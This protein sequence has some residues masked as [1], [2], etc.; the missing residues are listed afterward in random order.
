MDKFTVKYRDCCGWE[1]VFPS[2][3]GDYEWAQKVKACTW[4]R[5]G[6]TITPQMMRIFKVEERGES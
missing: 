3:T 1:E 2:L 6:E 5:N 4:N